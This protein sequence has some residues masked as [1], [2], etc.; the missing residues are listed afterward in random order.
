MKFQASLQFGDNMVGYYAQ[1]YGVVNFKSH[2]NREYDGFQPSAHAYCEHIEISVIAPGKQDLNLYEWYVSGGVL[3]GRIV[4]DATLGANAD[5]DETRCLYFEEAH[6][7]SISEHY[8][9]DVPTR[10]ILVIEFDA[11]IINYSN[12]T[13]KH[14]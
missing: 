6:C 7:Y 1:Q 13:F 12:Q 8:D 2:F 5:Q 3:N 9:I 11:Q 14:L 4:F 10:R